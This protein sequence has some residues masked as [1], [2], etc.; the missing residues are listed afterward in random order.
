MNS[1]TNLDAFAGAVASKQQALAQAFQALPLALSNISDAI[2]PS[3][4]GGPAL[5][6]RL[7][8]KQ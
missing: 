6:A 7:H 2:D 5:R 3:A 8:S 1:V 4:A